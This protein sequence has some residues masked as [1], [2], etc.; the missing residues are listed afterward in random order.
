MAA[1]TSALVAIVGVVLGWIAIEIACK[2]CLESGRQAI[3]RSLNPDYDPDDDAVSVGIRAPLNPRDPDNASATSSD[4]IKT[5]TVRWDDVETNRHSSV[6]PWEI[7][8]AGSV[9][10]SNSLITSGLKRTRIGLPPG[11]PEFPVPV[12][13][14]GESL[15]FQKVLQGQEILGFNSLYDGVDSQN[16]HLSE[17]RT[18]LPGSNSSGIAAIGNGMRNPHVNSE[19]SCKG[20]GFGESIRFHNV[21]KGQEIFP[22]SPYGR[23][24]TTNEVRGNGGLGISDGVQDLWCQGQEMDG[25][26]DAGL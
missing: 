25:L 8:R 1:I 14:F 15:R 3:D 6:S 10:S 16:L 18:F 23:A 12:L 13:D 7:E 22:K 20:I 11:Q 2:P 19:V 26:N 24:L 21:L 4:A 5:K 9:S 17:M